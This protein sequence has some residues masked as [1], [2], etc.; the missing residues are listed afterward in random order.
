MVMPPSAVERA[1]R[2]RPNLSPI[3]WSASALNFGLFN[4]CAN[5]WNLRISLMTKAML[6][7]RTLRQ[8]ENEFDVK[9]KSPVSSINSDEAKV[10]DL[11]TVRMYLSGLEL[12]RYKPYLPGTIEDLRTLIESLRD[13]RIV[14]IQYFYRLSGL[15]SLCLIVKGPEL[16]V[17]S[18]SRSFLKHTPSA[19]VRLADGGKTSYIMTRV[20]EDKVYD[21]LTEI[22]KQAKESDLTITIKRADAYAGYTHNL[23]SRLLKSDGTWDDDIS[24]LLSQIRS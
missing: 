10:L 2:A 3:D 15:A 7:K 6:G 19:T 13:R 9:L 4:S 21:I 8:L 24:G 23:Y 20:P 18:L 17:Q 11:L 14:N 1:I 22:P 5:N 12:G 16:Y